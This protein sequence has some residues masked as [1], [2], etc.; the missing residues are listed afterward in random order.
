MNYKDHYKDLKSEAEIPFSATDTIQK[1][2]RSKYGNDELD[3]YTFGIELEFTPHSDEENNYDWNEIYNQMSQNSDVLKEYDEYVE[4]ERK[5]LN[6]HW[7][8]KI[9][10][11]DDVYGPVDPDTFDKYNP[12]PFDYEYD[13][14]EEYNTAYDKWYH[15]SNTVSRAYERWKDYY[16]LDKLSDFISG[17][18]PSDYVDMD[19]YVV[20]PR[21]DKSVA[22]ENAMNYISKNMQQA[23][24]K[25]DDANKNRWA[26][27]PDMEN[28]EI[29]SKHLNQN[30]FHLV[31]E[32]CEY[33]E[34][35][36]TNGRTSAHVHIGLPDDF[37]EFDLLAMTTLVDEKAIKSTVGP[38]RALDSFAKL[39]KS[40]HAAILKS[41]SSK[42]GEQS[43]KS[44]FISNKDISNSLRFIDRNHGTNIKVMYDQGTIEFRYLDSRIASQSPLLIN[45]I[46]YFLLLPKIAKS[47]NKIVLQG[48]DGNVI[49]VRVSGGIKFY[50]DKKAPT[51]NLPAADIKASKPIE[52]GKY[53]PFVLP[54]VSDILSDIARLSDILSTKK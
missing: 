19:N 6:K 51:T 14:N 32:I 28:I 13:S 39:R 16:Y 52:K 1:G 29:R 36:N 21:F 27:G 37:D 18:D 23:V 7:N 17:L 54:K 9:D 40:L 30:E 11:W 15:E 10:D 34:K 8:G 45:W 31:T 24:V 22:V 2:L 46:K 4:S 25:G 43:D 44:Y 20:E 48:Q 50:Y 12:K 53:I 33:V 26:V 35:H 5:R 42:K 47:R 38:E 41:I 3:A 49:A